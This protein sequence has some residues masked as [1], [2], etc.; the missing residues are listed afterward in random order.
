MGPDSSQVQDD[1]AI[2]DCNAE[3][4]TPSDW[5]GKILSME[6]KLIVD[7]VES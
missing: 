4:Q 1:F 3:P 7:V 2:P 5:E 6:V